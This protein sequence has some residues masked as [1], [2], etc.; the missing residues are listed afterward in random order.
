M[1]SFRSWVFAVLTGKSSWL[2]TAELCCFS[3]KMVLLW[4]AGDVF[5]T[6]YFVVNESPTQFCVC[7]TVQ[8]LVDVA[9]LL[10]VFYYGQETRFK[11]G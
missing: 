10:Q 4:L 1:L 11:L 2:V 6:T 5:K 9:I 3:V 8:I 7:G